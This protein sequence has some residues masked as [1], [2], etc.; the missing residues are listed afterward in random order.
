MAL[1][2]MA[3]RICECKMLTVQVVSLQLVKCWRCAVRV[4]RVVTVLF[5]YSVRLTKCLP[6]TVW[7]MYGNTAQNLLLHVVNL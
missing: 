1:Q 4:C 5:I 2:A 3:Q 7:P 6:V